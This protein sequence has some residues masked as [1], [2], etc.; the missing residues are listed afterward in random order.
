MRET[1]HG[2]RYG[3]SVSRKVR[4]AVARNRAKRV[5]REIIRRHLDEF[6]PRAA[7]ILMS[8]VELPPLAG[9]FALLDQEFCE[10]ASRAGIMRKA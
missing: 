10:L 8:R 7:F 9:S 3:V 1:S 4:G 6:S 2:P 5:M